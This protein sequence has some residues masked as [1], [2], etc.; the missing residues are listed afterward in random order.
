V[1]AKMDAASM[2]CWTGPGARPARAC[3]TSS[4]CS[5]V[6]ESGRCARA[7]GRPASQGGTGA[8]DPGGGAGGA[9]GALWVWGAAI[10]SAARGKRHGPATFL[11]SAY[12]AWLWMAMT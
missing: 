4:A 2:T 3:G 10:I 12:L 9:R 8:R 5:A 6:S 7:G 11:H 1:I